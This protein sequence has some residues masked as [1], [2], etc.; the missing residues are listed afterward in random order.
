MSFTIFGVGSLFQLQS[1]FTIYKYV[2]IQSFQKDPSVT[3]QL[4]HMELQQGL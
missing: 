2:E 3:M 1:P 4:I